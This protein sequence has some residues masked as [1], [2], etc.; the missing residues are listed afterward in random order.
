MAAPGFREQ[1][2]GVK[3]LEFLR[4]GILIPDGDFF[5]FVAQRQGEA[6][7]RADAI[8]VGPDMADDAKRAVGADGF[9]DAVNDFGILLH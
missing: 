5:A 2:L 3:E 6:E 8:A 4:H 7:L 9:D 1:A